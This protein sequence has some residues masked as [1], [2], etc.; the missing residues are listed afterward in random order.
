M[1]M[2]LNVCKNILIKELKF[3]V[4]E[5]KNKFCALKHVKKNHNKYAFYCENVHH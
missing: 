3:L 4:F 2:M 1:M 5:K